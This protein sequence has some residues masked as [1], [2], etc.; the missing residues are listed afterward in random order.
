L[1][2]LSPKDFDFAAEL[3]MLPGKKPV[4]TKGQ[5]ASR[6]LRSAPNPLA[7]AEIAEAFRQA[8]EADCWETGIHHPPPPTLE[9]VQRGCPWVDEMVRIGG[10]GYE[11]PLW[12]KSVL[13]ATFIENGEEVVHR[14]SNK[15]EGYTQEETDEKFDYSKKAREEK[16]IGPPLCATIAAAAKEGK[17]SNACEGC[18]KLALG[19]TPLHWARAAGA[20]DPAGRVETGFPV[21]VVIGGKIAENVDDAEAALLAA[22]RPIFERGGVL[23]HPIMHTV[24]AADDRKT[25]TVLLKA[26][27]AENIIYDLAK[28]AAI[29]M[30]FDM[31]QKKW[32]D[33]N[34]P[35]AVANILLRK[36]QWRFPRIAGVTTTPTMRS[37]GSILERAGF[38]PSTQLL[39][40]P[41]KHLTIPAIPANPSKEDAAEAL[42]L[43]ES[44][45]T[46]FPFKNDL[47]RAVALAGLMVPVLRAGMK[48]APMILLLA[49]AAGTGKSFLID[50]AAVILTGRICPVVTGA[51]DEKEMEKR[52]GALVLESAGIV[53]LDNL[54]FD[55]GGPL[56]CQMATQQVV[57]VRILGLSE[58]PECEWRGALF[59][60]G[61]NISIKEDMS[62]RTLI[63]NMD[64][65]VERPELR[66]FKHNP[67][68]KV[69]ADRGKFIAAILTIARAWRAAGCPGDNEV[70]KLAGYSEWERA[71]RM[72]LI[73]LGK[74][75]VVVSMEQARE[76]DPVGGAQREL[77][78]LWSQHLEL[79]QPYTAAMLIE[80]AESFELPTTDEPIARRRYPEFYEL[81][82]RQGGTRGGKIE[83]KFIGNWLRT[84]KDKIHGG[85]QLKLVT[86]SGSHG[87]KY[88]LARVSDQQ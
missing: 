31:R 72:P 30:R 57:R 87:N 25:E 6:K 24:P 27:C 77:Y 71:I 11:E 15:Y 4:K 1:F 38:D 68:A 67:I 18:P 8:P 62:R 16:G 83:P 52:L 37:D 39:Y 5:R 70:S 22:N 19:K 41:D 20:A 85:H 10:K 61:N 9:A 33:I 66:Q 28:H 86:K 3:A 35:P 80:A 73:W 65:R 82:T 74:Q 45:L 58:M 54:T 21:I 12:H 75:D 7:N 26:M 46:E 48:V 84:M 56:L 34:P 55:I 32:V 60:N 64:A 13:L 88:C 78:R 53:S 79:N 51:E 47:D 14:F 49:P 40:L 29:F 81:L 17:C 23:V 69:M 43:L 50:L 59:A 42:A 44:L 36:G 63:S 76:D 2:W